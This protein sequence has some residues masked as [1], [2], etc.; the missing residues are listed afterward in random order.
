MEH[1][2]CPNHREADLVRE[3]ISVYRGGM[4]DT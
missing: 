2:V 4:Y 1:P 3:R